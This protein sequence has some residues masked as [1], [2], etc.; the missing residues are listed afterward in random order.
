M[1]G[2]RHAPAQLA[3][4]PSTSSGRTDVVRFVLGLADVLGKLWNLPN[5]LIGFALGYVALR[6]G[7]M[8]RLGHNALEFMQSPL[9]DR[10]NP[11]G[12]LALG[13]VILYGSRAYGCADHE[14][15]HTWQGQFLGPLY[16]PL[17]ALGMALSLLSY[18]VRA[19]RRPQCSAFHGR[20]NFMEGWPLSPTLYGQAPRA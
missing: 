5:S 11:H 7:G 19:L 10:F 16:L 1:N 4:R 20:L 17:N 14:R 8:V 15:V 9:M 2:E 3:R 6:F 12:A 18:P 13:N